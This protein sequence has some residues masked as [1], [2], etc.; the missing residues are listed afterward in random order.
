M[1]EANSPNPENGKIQIKT[2]VPKPVIISLFASLFVVSLLTVLDHYEIVYIGKTVLMLFRWIFVVAVVAY[3]FYKKSL[4][5]WIL[6]SMIVGAE[7]GYD[8]PDIAVKMRLLLLF[9][10]PLWLSELPAIRT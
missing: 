10:L 1:P 4:T 8:V 9:S 7:F 3:A 6:I 2:T 5:T